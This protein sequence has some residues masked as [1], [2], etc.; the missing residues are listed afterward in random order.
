MSNV[1]DFPTAARRFEPRFTGFADR[2]RRSFESQ[3]AMTLLGARLVRV[4]PGSQS[5]ELHNH[6][7][8][9]EFVY[10]FDLFLEL[11]ASFLGVLAE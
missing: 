9:E 3:G 8:D 7:I 4:E 10:I 1:A 6:E 11:L 5:S 2:T